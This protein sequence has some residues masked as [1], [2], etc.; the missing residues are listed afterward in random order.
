MYKELQNKLMSLIDKEIL[1][2]I[3]EGRSRKRKEKAKIKGVYDRIF[4]LEINNII[5]SFSYSDLLCKT[6][7]IKTM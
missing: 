2:I 1:V 5:M 3:D 4:T 6:I 7:T